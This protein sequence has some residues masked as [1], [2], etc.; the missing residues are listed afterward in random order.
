MGELAGT[1]M[2]ETGS[3]EAVTIEEAADLIRVSRRHL[4]KLMA[5]G[6]GP[7]VI[8]LGRRR[9]IR[10]DALLQWLVSREATSANG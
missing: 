6:E 3:L 5:D 1:G 7:P 9:I 8:Q 4:Q 10:R 2:A